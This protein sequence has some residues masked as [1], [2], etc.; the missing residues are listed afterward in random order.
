MKFATIILWLC[1][2]SLTVLGSDTEQVLGSKKEGWQIT[3]SPA[4]IISDFKVYDKGKTV[5]IPFRKDQWGGPSWYVR[6]RDGKSHGIKLSAVKSDKLTFSGLDNGISF[7]I[8][9]KKLNGKPAV[10]ASVTNEG[11]KKFRPM[12]AGIR[13]GFD[14][15]QEKYP[16]WNHKLM[17][18][19]LRCEPTHHWGFAMSPAG[20]ILGWVCPVPTASYSINYLEYPNGVGGHRIYTANIDFINQL[21]LPNRHPQHLTSLEPGE[22]KTWTVLLTHIKALESVKEE[23]SALGEVPVFNADY[24]TIGQ[25]DETRFTIL[26]PEVKALYMELPRGGQ[27]IIKPVKSGTGKTEYLFN[28]KLPGLY[29]LRAECENGK[30]AEGTIF[31]RHGW[32]WYLEKARLEALRVKP[33]QTANAECIY[34]FFSYF[35]GRKHIPD[36][37]IDAECENV[38]WKYFPQHYDFAINKLYRQWRLCDSGI[39]ASILADRYEVTGDLKALEYAAHLCNF[40]ITQQ[41]EDG[42]YY[43]HGKTH[44]TSVIYQ[45][46]SIM[47]VLSEEKIPAAKDTVWKERYLEHCKSVERAMDDLVRRRDNVKTEGQGTYE[48]SMIANSLAIVSVNTFQEIIVRYKFENLSKS[49]FPSIHLIVLFLTKLS[50]QIV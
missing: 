28:E 41:G 38:F 47:E 2:I 1:T 9:Y 23:L 21:P 39:W 10:V 32:K 50:F 48:D 46:K 13:I 43:A 36:S 15:Y 12:S 11:S 14:S 31:V 6:T 30:I 35:L 49:I 19:V 27:T 22:T 16:T 44:Y 37:R 24:Y 25:G 26:G 5:S 34:P 42:G 20:N 3:V 33:T 17:P 8:R 40:L 29:T 45:A 7:T 4:G 18:N